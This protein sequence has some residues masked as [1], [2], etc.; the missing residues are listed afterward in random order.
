MKPASKPTVK[1]DTIEKGFY[2][3]FTKA[4]TN[5]SLWQTENYPNNIEQ[6][7]YLTI[8]Q[9]GVTKNL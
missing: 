8:E 2:K 4:G 7:M 3:Q 5:F 1:L 9:F 6:I